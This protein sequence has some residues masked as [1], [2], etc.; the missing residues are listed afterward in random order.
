[1]KAFDLAVTRCHQQVAASSGRPLITWPLASASSSKTCAR[2]F[3]SH[4][5]ILVHIGRL[6]QDSVSHLD[7]VDIPQHRFRQ[8]S[9]L[10]VVEPDFV[11]C[12]AKAELAPRLC[13]YNLHLLKVQ[14][15]VVSRSSSPRKVA[16]APVTLTCNVLLC[17]AATSFKLAASGI[18]R[19]V[20]ER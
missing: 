9:H 4:E 1:M 13:S 18:I 16:G 2:M 17:E 3:Q 5:E 8:F 6:L 19:F 20:E 7:Q 12:D 14:V 10:T 15:E 11:S